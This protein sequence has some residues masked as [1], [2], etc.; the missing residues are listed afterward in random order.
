MVK[1]GKE[2]DDDMGIAYDSSEPRYPYGTELCF[3]DDL[4]ESLNL[5]DAKVGDKIEIKAVAIV[6]RKSERMEESKEGSN[7]DKSIDMQLIEVET[8]PV[9]TKKASKTSILYG[10]E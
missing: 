8:A 1:I 7:S 4:L 10:D 3:K 6:M 2:K 9:T 5:G